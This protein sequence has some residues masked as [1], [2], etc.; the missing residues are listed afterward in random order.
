LKS[1][2][3][4]W[5]AAVAFVRLGYLEPAAVLLGLADLPYLHDIE[6][7]ERASR[8]ESGLVDGLGAEQFA[9]LKARGAAL[10]TADAVAYLRDQ[11][12]RVLSV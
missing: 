8:I 12:D 7:A 5:Q 11:V 4:F 9:V 2:W 1:G 10:D 6:A 3:R